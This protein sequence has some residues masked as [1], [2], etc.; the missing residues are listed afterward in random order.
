MSAA[1]LTPVMPAALPPLHELALQIACGYC[2]AMPG[3]PCVTRIAV[4]RTMNRADAIKHYGPSGVAQAPHRERRHPI[5]LAWRLGYDEGQ[6]DA[7]SKF[8]VMLT[9]LETAAGV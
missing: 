1:G 3:E 6:S 8:D 5:W 9:R 7:L 2:G 4:T